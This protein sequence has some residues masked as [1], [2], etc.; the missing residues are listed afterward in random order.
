MGAGNVT[1]TT[2]WVNVPNNVESR[3]DFQRW[4]HLK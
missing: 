3:R 4:Q 1:Y 2:H